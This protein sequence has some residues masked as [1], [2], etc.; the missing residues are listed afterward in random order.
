MKTRGIVFLEKNKVN[1]KIH[2]YDHQVK[3]ADFASKSTGIELKK[4]IKTLVIC[5]MSGKK[6]YFALMPGDKSLNLKTAAKVCGEKKM[7]MSTVEEAQKLTGY[8]VGGISPFGSN[9]Q[10]PVIMEQ[11]LTVFNTVGINGGGRGVI[12]ELS[13]NDI[14]TL[15]TPTITTLSQ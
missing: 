4:M 11:S 2:T 12:V 1:F 7:R 9:K 10:L 13:P 15:L 6:F 14:I 8:L 3:G 5:D